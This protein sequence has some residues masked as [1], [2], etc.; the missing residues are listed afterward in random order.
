MMVP[1]FLL[2]LAAVRGSGGHNQESHG[3]FKFNLHTFRMQR[4][5][6]LPLVAQDEPELADYDLQPVVKIVATADAVQGFTTFQLFVRPHVHGASLTVSEVFGD[7]RDPLVLPPAFQVEAPFGASV[8]AVA[9]E[10][11]RA[12]KQAN[13]DS[14]LTIG[15]DVSRL[16]TP[17]GQRLIATPASAAV[18]W[19]NW[20]ADRGI[21]VRKTAARTVGATWTVSHNSIDL[22]TSRASSLWFRLCAL[23]MIGPRISMPRWGAGCAPT[24]ASPPG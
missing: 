17:M 23:V 1:S 12:K 8:G 7:A 10:I 5:P 24:A 6:Y 18:P 19:S 14:W 3:E 21:E 13:A 15:D 16:C 20:T 4:Y 2:L 11:Q 9:P 22:H